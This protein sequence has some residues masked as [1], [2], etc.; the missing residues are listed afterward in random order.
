MFISV[1]WHAWPSFFLKDIINQRQ[2]RCDKRELISL[3][4]MRGETLISV[5]PCRQ[6]ILLI[7]LEL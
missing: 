7:I 1:F 6:D 3:Q 5:R 4:K 2:N